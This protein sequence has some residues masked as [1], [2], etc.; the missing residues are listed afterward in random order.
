MVGAFIYQP[1]IGIKLKHKCLKGP[2]HRMLILCLLHMSIRQVHKL[3]MKLF[4]HLI[5]KEY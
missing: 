5:P 2:N 4:M 1:I 3:L